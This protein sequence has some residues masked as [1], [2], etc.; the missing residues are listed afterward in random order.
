MDEHI[1]KIVGQIAGIGGLG[2]G[3][4]LIV[5]KEIIRKNIFP[6]LKPHQAY[7]LLRL[8]SILCWSI[9]LGG[10][11]AWAFTSR[12]A[13]PQVPT[14]NREVITAADADALEKFVNNNRG[15]IIHI[16][17]TV[18][19]EYS[20]VG[21]KIDAKDDFFIAIEPCSSLKVN[22]DNECAGFHLLLNG[23]DHILEFY[24]GNQRLTGY[25]AVAENMWMHQGIYYILQ[26]ISSAQVLLQTQRN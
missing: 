7:S 13:T 10:I 1:L 18:N 6:K 11:A 24:K 9:A 17:T 14:F 15:R 25:F 20:R 2:M 21:D 4:A 19:P 26:S 23:Q 5:F 3:V 16:N 12:S 8:I 22:V